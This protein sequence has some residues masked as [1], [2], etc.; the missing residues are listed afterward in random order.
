VFPDISRLIRDRMEGLTSSLTT[1]R[2]RVRQ[3]IASEMAK[4]VAKALRDL[5]Q[6]V[7]IR[8]VRPVAPEVPPPPSPPFTSR[9]DDDEDEDWHEP[10]R[11]VAPRRD[12]PPPPLATSYVEALRTGVGITTWLLHRKV[13]LLAGLGLGLAAGLAALSTHPL[14][15]TGLAVAAAAAELIAIT[16]SLPSP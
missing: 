10:P 7:L 11:S 2:E 3:A 5:L 12:V 4:A 6:A 13:P 16:Q 8:D 14:V 9:W 15:Q 1:L